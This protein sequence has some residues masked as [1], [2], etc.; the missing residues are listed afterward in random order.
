MRKSTLPQ[1]AKTTAV[2]AAGVLLS[3]FLAAELQ[4]LLRPNMPQ[5]IVKAQHANPR[6]P[7]WGGLSKQLQHV[8]AVTVYVVGPLAGIGVGVFVA[9]L[10]KRRPV[11]IACLCLIPQ[12][13]VGLFTDYRRAWAHSASG[14]LHYLFDHS[15]PFIL[16]ILAVI[17][18]DFFRQHRIVNQGAGQADAVR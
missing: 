7:E 3:F 18:V 15:L 5:L 1:W 11:L 10:Q 14:V 9:L 2:T 13:F 16:A 12:F 6:G 17:A 4:H 8:A